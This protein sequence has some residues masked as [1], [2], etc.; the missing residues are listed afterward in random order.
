MKPA[1]EA[2]IRIMNVRKSIQRST[3]CRR[4][5]SPTVECGH[6]ELNDRHSW[7]G[8]HVHVSAL[9]RA[10]PNFPD[11]SKTF[12]DTQQKFPVNSRREFPIGGPENGRKRDVALRKSALFFRFSL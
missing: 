7:G 5:V 2:P 4:I 11:L 10:P 3:N 9:C 8:L 12:P 6:T 1:T